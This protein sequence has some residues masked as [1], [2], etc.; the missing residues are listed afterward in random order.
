VNYREAQNFSRWFSVAL[1]VSVVISPINATTPI[2]A[3][4]KSF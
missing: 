2:N 3:D 4:P 1:G